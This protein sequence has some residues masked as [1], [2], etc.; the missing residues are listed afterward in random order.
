MIGVTDDLSKQLSAGE[1]VQL[2]SAAL[3]GKGGGRADMAQGGGPEIAKLA[4]AVEA[5]KQRLGA[6]ADA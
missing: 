2:G 6:A 5:I 3:G 1:L 4:E